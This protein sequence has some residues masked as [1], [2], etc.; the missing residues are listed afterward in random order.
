MCT[1]KSVRK[2]FNREIREDIP[3][4]DDTEVNDTDLKGQEDAVADVVLPRQSIERDTVHK[5]VKEKRRSNAE[6]QPY[7][8]LGTKSV[9]QDLSGIGS[10]DTGL[11]V[12]EDTVEKD[13]D[14]EAFSKAAIS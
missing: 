6:V 2:S 4:F 14:D 1:Y 3:G 11:D 12:V 5:L 10:H 7:K 13:G 9:R 8:T